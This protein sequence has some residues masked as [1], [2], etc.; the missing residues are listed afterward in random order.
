LHD[1]QSSLTILQAE[2]SKLVNIIRRSRQQLDDNRRTNRLLLNGYQERS[3]ILDLLQKRLAS[4]GVDI[5]VDLATGVLRLPEALLFSSGRADFSLT[6][7][8]SISILSKNLFFVLPCYTLRDNAERAKALCQ[9]ELPSHY[10]ESIFIEGHTDDLPISNDEFK[11]NW[12]LSFRRAKNTFLE[13]MKT[14]PR[15]NALN[16]LENQALIGFSSY[17]DRR[18]LD[19]NKTDAGRRKNRRIDLRLIM[20]PAEWRG[21]PET[22]D[23]GLQ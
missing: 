9:D 18:P 3:K 7:K 15:L 22:I 19:T 23:I 13:L 5:E 10:L 11:D 2:N 12:D 20:I 21:V 6:G 16:N 8:K 17:A 4:E 1:L 14:E